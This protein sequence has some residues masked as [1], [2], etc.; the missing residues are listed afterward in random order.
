[1]ESPEDL[2]PVLVGLYLAAA[3][4]NLLAAGLGRRRR[5]VIRSLAWLAF[6]VVF[7]VLAGLAWQGRPLELP[8]A[9]KRGIDT[10]LGPVVLFA[11][12]LS[13][14]AILYLGRNFFVA[15]PVAW[16]GLNLSLVLLGASLADP[17]FAAV[18]LRP[19]NVPIVGL[20]YLL[21]FFTWLG[22]SQAVENDRRLEAGRPPREH[23][24]RRPVL[25]WP[26]LVYIELIAM[27]ILTTGL[28]LWSLWLR[29]PLEP[30]A[31]P[32]LTPN[33]A[34][35]PWYFVGLQEML[36][37]FDPAI[38]GV[39]IPA[40][41]ILGLMAIP[42]LDF[43]PEGSGYYTIRRRRFAYPVFLFGFF[44][45]WIL[46]IL[47]GTFLRGPN[48]S[49]F[50]PFEPRDPHKVLAGTN[51]KLSEY[52]WAVWLGRGLPVVPAGAGS[53]SRLGHVLYRE[54]FG[55]G[56]LA[57]YFAAVPAI[58]GRTLLAGFRRRL[59]RTG[60]LVL[61]LLLLVMLSL[62]LKMLLHWS[63]HLSYVVSMP[64]YFFNF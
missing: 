3:G 11:G 29:A 23:D 10:V 61:S 28:T 55:L 57:A 58:L 2:T 51:V 48:W 5:P 45:L 31:N 46:L 7:A 43:N 52:F 36:V 41:A 37:F 12:S 14:L 26:D 59:G 38:A 39:I 32:L 22:A 15:K 6:A 64:E 33:P 50:G 56:V 54:I 24:D 35:A 20:V 18:A 17:Q 8:Q 27:V 34:K 62:P 19:D 63:F 1:M 60:Y 53:L 44:Q 21:G 13:A 25:V 47:V 42:Y 9:V 16:T 40:L 4:V 30:P 49:F